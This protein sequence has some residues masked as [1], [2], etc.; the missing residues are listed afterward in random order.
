M[1]DDAP[2]H[3]PLT[4]RQLKA[5]RQLDAEL[6]PDP[7]VAAPSAI[8]APSPETARRVMM[9]MG[10]VAV[11]VMT[12]LIGLQ[13]APVLALVGGAASI[14]ATRALL[15]ALMEQRREVDGTTA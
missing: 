3:Q 8:A 1:Y 12:L 15:A 7:F 4:A 11:A 6:G 2:R 9:R 5:L 10:M 14:W 13:A